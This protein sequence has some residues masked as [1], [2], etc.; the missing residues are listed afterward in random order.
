MDTPSKLV[1]TLA[2]MQEIAAGDAKP[3]TIL[4]KAGEDL[5]L[6]S[7]HAPELLSV[8]IDPKLASIIA[9]GIETLIGTPAI[10]SLELGLE[11]AF[12]WLG[13]S[14]ENGFEGIYSGQTAI[15]IERDQILFIATG[16]GHSECG[17]SSKE[18]LIETLLTETATDQVYVGRRA[19]RYLEEDSFTM[20]E[21]VEIATQ[22][23]PA[24]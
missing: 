6:E 14:L 5:P 13:L 19:R 4:L 18:C 3:L 7:L 21:I 17:W 2:L 8:E 15:R 1:T 16:G 20:D 12:N 23:Q 11:S 24:T 9:W 10:L 22:A